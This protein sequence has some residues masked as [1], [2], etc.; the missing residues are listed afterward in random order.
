MQNDFCYFLW[1]KWR[2]IMFKILKHLTL[3]QWIFFIIAGLMIVGQVFIELQLPE[4]MEKIT[5]TLQAGGATSEILKNGGIMLA[6]ALAGGIISVLVGLISAKIGAKL[7]QTLRSKVYGKV[8]SFSP[9]EMHK[10]SVASLITR[11]T[12][13]I[14]QV[15][16][17]I[18][19]GF[20]V[21][22]KA[23]TMAI[24]SIC[25]IASKS[26]QWSFSTGVAILILLIST[27]I[28]ISLCLPKFKII[29]KQTD[30]L[31]RITRENL[32]GLR[33]I[34]AFNAENY[35]QGKFDNINTD[36]TK[37]NV[38]THSVLS[39][40]QPIMYV[41]IDALSISIYVIGALLIS[42]AG[43]VAT[44]AQLFSDTMVFFSYAMMVISSFMMLIM[45]FMI[46]PRAQVCAKR[47]QEVL[48]T[49]SSI[50][51]GAGVTPTEKGTIKFNDVSFGYQDAKEPVLRSISFDV[52]Q[53]ESVAIIGSTGSGKSTLV[54][55]IPRLYDV[56][57]GE[58]FVD[59]ENVKDYKLSEL[60]D[61]I[62]YIS[63]KAMLFSG[64]IESN[65]AMGNISGKKVDTKDVENAI[66]Q[67]QSS[68][69]V[70]NLNGTYKAEVYQ[71]G[72]NFSGGQKQR[73]SIARALARKP[74]ILIFDDSF[75]ALDYQ[76]D[77]NLRQTL[78]KEFADTTTII[79]AQRVGTIKNCDKILV[80]DNGQIVASGTHKELLNNSPL[81]KEIALS[82]LSKEELEKD[83]TK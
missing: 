60:Y 41:V 17:T 59:G 69:F 78:K 71:Q 32:T 27:L 37:T 46:L 54:K 1:T 42:R 33:V 83:E 66:K 52:K 34:K 79:I 45:I 74:E 16:R 8:N 82:Q 51:D 29:Q 44:K 43:D 76:T 75:S 58:V 25:K 10:F 39:F 50:L 56:T 63:Q 23:P 3:K 48:D 81:Y 9:A 67:S 4:Y 28:I 26:W 12:N 11:S 38:F 57:S 36:L 64:T 24:L 40:F 20:Q 2:Y 19:T 13:D 73:I 62:G 55:L 68:A 7:S 47:I 31:N 30:D 35:E 53:G 49:N 65:I 72:S 14:T 61:R 77:K 18:S 6:C 70:E 22:I 5:N 15:Q 80:L 21:I